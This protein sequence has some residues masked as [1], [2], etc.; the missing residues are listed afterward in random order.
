MSPWIAI[1]LHNIIIIIVIITI[2]IIIFIVSSKPRFGINEIVTENGI[3]SDEAS[4]AN[5]LKRPWL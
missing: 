4:I 5:E 1:Q 3:V 2:I